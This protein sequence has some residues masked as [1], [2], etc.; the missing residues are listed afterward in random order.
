[1][2]LAGPSTQ[3]LSRCSACVVLAHDRI[4]SVFVPEV[5][6]VREGERERQRERDRERERERG[7]ARER[8]KQRERNRER[9]RE[10][11]FT[12]VSVCVFAGP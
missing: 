2:K 10:R 6:G 9:E 4:T 8:E 1:M 5:D 12:C 3:L 7:R 11:E